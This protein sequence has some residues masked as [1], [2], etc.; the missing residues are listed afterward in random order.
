MMTGLS[1]GYS[2]VPLL[3]KFGW[4]AEREKR[5]QFSALLRARGIGILPIGGSS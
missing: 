5:V 3:T 2:E 4:V 1:F